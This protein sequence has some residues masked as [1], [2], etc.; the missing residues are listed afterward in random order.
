MA[1]NLTEKEISSILDSLQFFNNNSEPLQN[2][3]DRHKHALK[4]QLTRIVIPPENIEKLKQKIIKSFY[5]SIVSPG[6]SVGVNAAQCIAEPITQSTLNTFH[7]AGN[8]DMNVTLGFGRSKEIMNCTPNQSTPSMVIYFDKKYKSL[9]DLHKIIDRFPQT[10]LYDLTETYEIINPIDYKLQWWHKFFLKSKDMEKPNELEWV[11]RLKFDSKKMYERNCSP[12]EIA[13]KLQKSYNDIRIIVSPFNLFTIDILVNCSSISIEG[14]KSPEL[15]VLL[16][17]ETDDDTVYNYYMKKIVYPEIIKQHIIGIK[18]IKK[19]YPRKDNEDWVV[20]TQGTNM[21]EILN[22]T[23]VDS[24]RTFSND[25]W[26]IYHILD[27]E[28]AREYLSQEFTK[29]VSM[30]GNYINARHVDILVDKMCHTGTMRAMARFGIEAN[31]FS[32]ISKASFEEVMKHFINA[33]VGSEV[34]NINSISPNIAVG[35]PIRAGTGFN[36]VKKVNIVVKKEH[37]ESQEPVQTNLN[38]EM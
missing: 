30:G 11:L 29:I 25:I 20:N 18:N 32:V 16:N 8:N 6:E 22:Q 5:E 9:K 35:K 38:D 1:R 24:F 21:R 15:R 23:G 7:H 4:N 19:V 33:A 3:I 13:D 27:I 31:Q 34:D 2:C 37:I 14:I 10:L 28:A 12:K 26:E 17:E 36:T